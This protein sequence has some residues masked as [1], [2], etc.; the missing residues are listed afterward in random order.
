MNEHFQKSMSTGPAVQAGSGG[1]DSQSPLWIVFRA[2]ASH[3]AAFLDVK[4]ALRALQPAEAV[5][6]CP[7]CT[8]VEKGERQ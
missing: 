5:V 6:H 3:P 8:C 4:T 2:L 1:A 7:N